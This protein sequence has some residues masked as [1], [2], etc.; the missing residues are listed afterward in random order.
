MATAFCSAGEAKPCHPTFFGGC[1][2]VRLDPC[3]LLS[4]DEN[5]ELNGIRA[6][7]SRNTAVAFINRHRLPFH[8]N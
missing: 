4:D 5:R 6:H 7:R 3:G 2:L 1:P 8:V